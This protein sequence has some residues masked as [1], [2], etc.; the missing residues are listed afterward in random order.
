MM[1]KLRK[2]KTH[3]VALMLS[4]SVCSR[5]KFPREEDGRK[6]NNDKSLQITACDRHTQAEGCPEEPLHQ[7][8]EDE[9]PNGNREEP[10]QS[11]WLR[12]AT[13]G[14]GGSSCAGVQ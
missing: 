14:N 12:E 4:S 2:V 10:R 8:A 11:R 13:E 9:N 6:Y 5:D 7:K 1:A 3:S